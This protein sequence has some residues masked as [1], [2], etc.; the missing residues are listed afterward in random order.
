MGE[1]GGQPADAER[2]VG[3]AVAEVAA[4]GDRDPGRGYSTQRVPMTAPG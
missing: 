4:E 2:E 1:E 3:V